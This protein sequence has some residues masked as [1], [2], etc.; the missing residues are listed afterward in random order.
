MMEGWMVL[1]VDGVEV[2]GSMCGTV[3]LVVGRGREIWR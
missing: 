1:I 2:V 3:V